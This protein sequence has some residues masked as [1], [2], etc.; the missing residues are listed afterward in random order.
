MKRVVRP[1]TVSATIW[2]R[3]SRSNSS[4]EVGETA[5]ASAPAA[6]YAYEVTAPATFFS[7]SS[8]TELYRKVIS[9]PSGVVWETTRPNASCS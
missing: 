3:A 8:P 7:T 4:V 1:S 5:R 6:S 9:A 2:P